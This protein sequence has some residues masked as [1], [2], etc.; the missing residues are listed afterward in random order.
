VPIAIVDL[1]A[2]T[3]SA[4]LVGAI[5][6]DAAVAVDE[7]A[8]PAAVEAVRKGKVRAAAVIPAGFGAAAARAL[9][10]PGA[11]RPEVVIHYDP[12]QAIAV[13]IVKGVLAEQVMKTVTQAAFSPESSAPIMADIRDTVQKSDQLDAPR[14]RDLLALF[15]SVE[16]VQRPN[17]AGAGTAG[18]ATAFSMPFSTRE[19]EVTSGAGRKYN[20]Y[21][22][23]FAGMSVQF[24][25]FMGIEL[26][27][28]VLLMRRQGLWQRLRAAPVSKRLLLGSRILSGTA[29]ALVLLAGIYAAAIAAFGVRIEGSVAGFAAVAVAFAVLTATFGLLIAAVGRT[30]EATRGIAIVA[31]LLLVMLGGA[32]VPTFVFPEWLQ[33]ATLVV[34]TRWA[35]D[36]LAAMTWRGLPLD[37]ALAPAAVLLGFSALFAWIAV[38]RFD[39]EE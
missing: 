36:G 12:S 19:Q 9:L 3:V 30:P 1:D 16:R 34:P 18:A 38:R 8:E 27:M 15:D 7:L 11:A 25:L 17:A 13:S 2:S 5:R 35:I 32:W 26:G 29:I 37:A 24:I 20:S 6:A 4:A 14:R 28:A 10:L 39:W 21:A 22:H 23:A 31:T 33:T